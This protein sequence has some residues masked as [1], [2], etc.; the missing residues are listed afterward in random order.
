MS[1]GAGVHNNLWTNIDV[2]VGTRPFLSS[3]DASKGAHAG[4]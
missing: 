4:E 3:G 2:G 1:P